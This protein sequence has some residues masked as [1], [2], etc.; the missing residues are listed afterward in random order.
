[1]QI[2]I[3][4]LRC[5]IDSVYC[6]SPSVQ[7]EA[8]Q[9]RVRAL[10]E[11]TQQQAEELAVWR[12][13]SQTAPTFEECETHELTSAVTQSQSNQE[14]TDEMTQC[15]PQTLPVQDSVQ[16]PTLDRQKSQETITVIREDEL[17]VSCSSNRLQGR[18]LFSR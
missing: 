2:F 12:L 10:S 16:T 17:L 5:P 1:M 7:V 9:I 4:T 13:A 15:S 6:H 14:Q 3:D 8:L 11:E 18:M